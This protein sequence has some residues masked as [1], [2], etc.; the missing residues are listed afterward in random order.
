MLKQENKKENDMLPE[1]QILVVEDEPEFAELVKARLEMAGYVVSIAWD[2]YAGTQAIL[3]KEFDLIILDLMMPAGGGLAILERIQNFPGKL[4]IPVVILTGKVIDNELKA[5]LSELN[6]SAIFAKP[7]NS[8]EFLS[9]IQ[10][11][12]SV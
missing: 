5:H 10:S 9:K 12:L 8:I 6:V 1:K 7:Y 4:H 2:A 11:L 3:K